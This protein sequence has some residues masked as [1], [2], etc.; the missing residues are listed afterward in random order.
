MCRLHCVSTVVPGVD[1]CE[2]CRSYR[3]CRS[4]VAVSLTQSTLYEHGIFGKKTPIKKYLYN[5][6]LQPDGGYRSLKDN[7]ASVPQPR[8]LKE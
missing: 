7:S 6:E 8:E 3:V 5:P 4:D 1:F 2:P